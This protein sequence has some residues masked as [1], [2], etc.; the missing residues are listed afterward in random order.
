MAHFSKL[1]TPLQALQKY[2]TEFDQQERFRSF[3]WANVS[4]YNLWSLWGTE[5]FVSSAERR[6][7][8]TV[9]PFD[10]WEELALFGSHYFLLVA[11]Q[12]CSSSQD[13]S[14]KTVNASPQPRERNPTIQ[15]ELMYEENPRAVGCQRFGSVIP[16]RSH[17][18]CSDKLGSFGG[19]GLMTRRNSVDIYGLGSLPFYPQAPPLVPSS[20]MCHTITDLGDVGSLLVGGRTSPDSAL[21]DCWLYHKWTNIWERV[22]DLPQPLYRHQAVDLGHGYVLVSTGRIHTRTISDSYLIWSRRQGWVKCTFG[23]MEAPS[24]TYGATFI[25]SNVP[26]P[27]NEAYARHG[28]LAGGLSVDGLLE[29]ELWEWELEN[30]SSKVWTIFIVTSTRRF[31]ENIFNCIHAPLTILTR[32][33]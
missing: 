25:A 31:I 3:G 30:I 14:P 21:S 22:D 17:D 2:P 28:V 10:E 13:P 24:P 33:L 7:L 4:V 5:E 15:F 11:N 12:R 20:R 26:N 19:M 27:Q 16:V 18:R 29:Q 23:G 32:C 6:N 8:D 9:E 1:Q